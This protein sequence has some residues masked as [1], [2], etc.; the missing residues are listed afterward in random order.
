MNNTEKQRIEGLKKGS[1][2][3]FNFLYS[4]YADS[5][6][7]FSLKL[8]KSRSE[9]QDVVQDTFLKI[10]IKREQLSTELSFKS[11]LYTIA[12]NKI[13]T[14]F[15]KRVD[16]VTIEDLR[17]YIEENTADGVDIEQCIINKDIK[18]NL[19]SLIAKLPALQARIFIMKTEEEL[20][21]Q[22]ISFKLNIPHQTVKN[23]L[24]KAMKCMRNE[25]KKLKTILACIHL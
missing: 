11:Y 18:Y 23:N 14:T 21:T 22:E 1:I 10:W 5:L 24:S 19:Y 2:D 12:K 15:Q 13:L 8:L 16:E 3:D 25:L 6:F 9:A 4:V 20:S 7:S 17:I